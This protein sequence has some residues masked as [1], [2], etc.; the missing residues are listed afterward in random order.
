MG[1]PKKTIDEVQAVV[2]RVHYEKDYRVGIMGGGYYIQIEYD[3][4]DIITG[5]LEVQ[6]GRKWY[7]SP[8]ATESEIVQTMLRAA[9]DSA[10]HQVREHFGY[11]KAGETIPKLIYGPHFDKDALY[12]ICGKAASYDARVG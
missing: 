7:I 2:N 9:L 6:R 8:H 12:D 1:Q 11:I 4:P 10:E 5:E 3:E